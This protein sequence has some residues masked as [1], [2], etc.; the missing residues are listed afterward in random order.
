MSQD[1]QEVNKK[2][3]LR[4]LKTKQPDNETPEKE[5]P[6]KKADLYEAIFAAITHSPAALLVEPNFEIA[7]VERNRGVK[8]LIEISSGQTCSEITLKRVTDLIMKYTRTQLCG[9]E[10]Y[11]FTVKDCIDCAQYWESASECLPNPPHVRFLSDP[12]LCWSRLPFDPIPGPT[13]LFDELFSR[14]TNARA[15]KAWIGSLFIAESYRQQYVWLFGEGNDGKSS[16]LDF[17]AQCIGHEGMLAQ[18]GAPTG[19]HWAAPYP[20]KRLVYFPDF[21]DLSSLDT[22]PLKQITGGDTIPVNPK[23][24]TPYMAKLECKLIFSSNHL[25][26]VNL[27][28]SNTRRL[29][30]AEMRSTELFDPEYSQKLWREGGAFLRSCFDIYAEECPQHGPIPVTEDSEEV[31]AAWAS[32]EDDEYQLWFDDF[33]MRDPGSQISLNEMTQ[34]IIFR[35][36]D[37][38][39]KRAVYD[40]L[41]KNGYR[42]KQVRLADNRRQWI[43]PNLSVKPFNSIIA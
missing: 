17:L 20:G 8:T 24:L 30:F 16:L 5:K 35:F 23:Y 14:M 33:F 41:H 12:G 36:K 21:K 3:N 7:V 43:Y 42:R 9:L 27:Q 1:D 13:P 40:W 11:R 4:S 10:A 34:R 2:S 29:I 15:V 32:R 19:D 18:S 26:S 6:P 39:S 38:K 25:P 22:G 37:F 31:L 28:K